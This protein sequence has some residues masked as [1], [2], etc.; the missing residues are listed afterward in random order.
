MMSSNSKKHLGHT[1][2]KR[3][4]QNFLQDQDVIHNIIAAINPQNSDFLIEIGPGLGAL[5]EPVA[6]QVDKLTVIELDRD[7]AKRLRH[8]PFLNQKLTVIEQDALNFNFREYF[9]TLNLNENNGIRIFGNLPYN[10]STPLIFHLLTFHDLIQDM[11]FMLQ[12]EVVK[13]LCAAP[14]SKTYGRLTVMAQY[15]CQ[16]IPVLEVPPSAFKPA[17]KVDSAVVRLVPHT[18]LPYPVKDISYLNRVVTQA[19]NQRR[20]TLRNSLSQLFTADQ[21]EALGM[22]LQARAENL[23]L[24]DYVSLANW[25]YEN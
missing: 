5:T 16:I 9:K 24:A 8:H 20:K 12:K 14:N 21:L 25:L 11:H 1:A 17:P 10:I 2:R 4:G 15:Y 7:L 13:R 23:S 18:I 22:N 6:E 19:F 3:F